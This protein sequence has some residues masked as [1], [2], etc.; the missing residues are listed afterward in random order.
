M[1]VTKCILHINPE[2]KFKCKENDFN[3]ITWNPSYAGGKPTL[4]ELQAVSG[5]VDLID[6]NEE[7]RR[8]REQEFPPLGDVLDEVLNV[9]DS[10]SLIVDGT[11]LRALQDARIQVKL[12]NPKAT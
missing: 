6:A 8:K 2:A 9:L 7:I 12:D 10:A 11:K 4:A 1:N 5:V 3:K